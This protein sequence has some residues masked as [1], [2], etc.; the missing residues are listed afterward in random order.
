MYFAQKGRE[1]TQKCVELALKTATQ[2]KIT[3]LV[4]ASGSGDT[5]KLFINAIGAHVVCVTNAYGSQEPGKAKISA[6]AREELESAGIKVL[7]ATHVL[8]GAERG[9]SKKHGG[10]SPVEL[11]ADTLRMFGQGVKVCVEIAVMAL[12][13]G[14]IPYGQE[15]V[16]TAGSGRG[17]DTV[18]LLTPAHANAILDTKIHEIV[19]KPRNF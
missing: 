11:M 5:A 13:A 8:S 15:V 16:A 3:H 4:V 6:A 9:I 17:A 10:V 18:V 2:R 12:D 1:N 14:L 19:C 7:A